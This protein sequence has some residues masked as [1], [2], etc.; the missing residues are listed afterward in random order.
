M[1]AFK[2]ICEMCSSTLLAAKS[3]VKTCECSKQVYK[4]W[5]TLNQSKTSTN[6][7]FSTFLGKFL[8]I[9]G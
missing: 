8:L 4:S 1:M 3:D 9:H 2:T 5:E 7:I 6:L